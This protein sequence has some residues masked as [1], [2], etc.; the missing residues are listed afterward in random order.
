VEDQIEAARR[1]LIVSG[2]L[3]VGRA[4]WEATREFA[5]ELKELTNRRLERIARVLEGQLGKSNWR[6]THVN[7]GLHLVRG[8]EFQILVKPE[9]VGVQF[10]GFVIYRMT[11]AKRGA[12]LQDLCG[13]KF[14]I[15]YRESLDSIKARFSPWFEAGLAR[16]LALWRE[17][18]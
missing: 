16:G 10:R 7:L 15:N 5:A 9:E 12:A 18:L 8:E 11:Y 13:A 4:E 1:K 2:E 6:F 14:Q 3:R 17:Q